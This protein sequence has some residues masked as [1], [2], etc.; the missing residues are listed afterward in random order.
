MIALWY[1]AD[2]KKKVGDINTSIDLTYKMIKEMKENGYTNEEIAE[3][4]MMEMAEFYECN[5]KLKEMTAERIA[6]R[7]R[8]R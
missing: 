6:I 2:T 7:E 4:F 3:E 5:K 1:I 8:L